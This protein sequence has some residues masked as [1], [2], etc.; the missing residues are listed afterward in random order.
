[1]Q[2]IYL[3]NNQVMYNSIMSA[4]RPP[5]K[6]RTSLG[7]N[8]AFARKESG[9]TQSQLAKKIG[10][11]QRVITYWEREPVAL[12]PQQLS[13]LADALDVSTDFL[14]GREEKKPRQNAPTGKA[15]KILS[16]ISTLPRKQQERLIEQIEISIAGYQAKQS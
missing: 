15:T 12:K 9:I 7:D 13:N 1:M 11:T 14:L 2:A 5:S 4:G 10:V 3:K 6:P 16:Q 8:I